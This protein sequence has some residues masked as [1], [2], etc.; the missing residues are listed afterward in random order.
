[1][2]PFMSMADTAGFTLPYGPDSEYDLFN[3][4]PSADVSFRVQ[5]LGTYLIS[6]LFRAE[7]MSEAGF[8]HDLKLV[9]LCRG[10]EL[11]FTGQRFDQ[12]DL[13]VLFY[14]ALN[15]PTKNGI[16]HQFEFAPEELLHSLNL[17][18]TPLNRQRVFDSLKRLHN[19]EVEIRGKD[20]QYMT[21][22]INRVLVDA[23]RGK[24]LVE[25]NADVAATFRASKVSEEI[26]DRRILG[27]DGLAKWLH[28][29]TMVFKGGFTSNKE[30]LYELCD[31]DT[32]QMR[33]FANKLDKALHLLESTARIESWATEE[34]RVRVVS[35][36]PRIKNSACGVLRPA[37]WP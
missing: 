12:W 8:V 29:A 14:C 6:N 36:A 25:T 9:T 27:R 7:Y 18:N 31:P 33:C 19:G 37:L 21:R 30:N 13:D 15:T 4:H 16:P 1:M 17:R 26:R 2:H 28:G 34:D 20:Y 32:K 10:K 23:G 24:C 11:F 35:K 3:T 5:R 22:F